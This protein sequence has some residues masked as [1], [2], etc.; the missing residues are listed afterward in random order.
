MSIVVYP[1]YTFQ[2]SNIWNKL[3]SFASQ[4]HAQNL[5]GHLL[6]QASSKEL[7][8]VMN[9][10]GDQLVKKSKAMK[11]RKNLIQAESKLQTLVFISLFLDNDY[12]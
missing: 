4:I 5:I 2:I 1:H 9:A 10:L 7:N 12:E 6:S 3:L 8:L 11:L